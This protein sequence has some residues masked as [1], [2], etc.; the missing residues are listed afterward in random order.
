MHLERLLETKEFK[1]R[2]LEAAMMVEANGR[3]SSFA[4][5]SVGEN[6]IFGDVLSGECDRSM[7]EE[8]IQKYLFPF[9]MKGF[10]VKIEGVVH[11]HPSDD[12]LIIPSAADLESLF[13][14]VDYG[15]TVEPSFKWMVIGMTSSEIRLLCIS[16]IRVTEA[17]VNE[18]LSQAE[19]MENFFFTEDRQREINRELGEIGFKV[20]YRVM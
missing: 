14:K 17:D 3:E 8:G 7:P 10:D 1:A 11:F 18:W 15:L 4:V 19:T 12:H 13:W 9:F 2:V 20:E 6:L 16:P 5:A